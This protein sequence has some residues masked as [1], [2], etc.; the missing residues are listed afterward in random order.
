M[1]QVPYRFVLTDKDFNELSELK[2]VRQRQY[3]RF[4]NNVGQAYFEIMQD[5]PVIGEISGLN[6]LSDIYG[7]HIY[8]ANQLSWRGIID[9]IVPEDRRKSS[10]DVIGVRASSRLQDFG[11]ILI[12][13]SEN[14]PAQRI[15][16]ANQK[17]GTQ[18]MQTFFD[19]CKAKENSPIADIAVGTISDPQ[20]SAGVD[21]TMGTQDALPMMDLLTATDFLANISFAD[22]W[23][24]D[25][26]NTF[27]FVANKGVEREVMFRFIENEPGNNIRDFA[28]TL[29]IRGVTNNPIGFAAGE[30][31]NLKI[32]HNVKDDPSIARFKL[33]Q[34]LLDIRTLDTEANIAEHLNRQLSQLKVPK[35]YTSIS[36]SPSIVPFHGWDLGDTVRVHIKR[37]VFQFAQPERK[38][39]LGATI[40]V[41]DT[42]VEYT[43][44]HYGEPKS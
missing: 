18:L 25:L 32:L 42:N 14:S 19:E 33:R 30:G 13:A 4:I 35:Y 21:M 8:R 2:R 16:L 17:I 43:A 1:A 22:Y 24:D 15:G 29:D 12:N 39:I 38:R 20:D 28:V 37:G 10:M 6:F 3:S 34:R 11:D 9:E 31:A 27:S 44:I 5:N 26:N 7:L 23:Y 41:D 36:L 40:T